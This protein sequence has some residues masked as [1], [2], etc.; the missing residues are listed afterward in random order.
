[1]GFSVYL[2]AETE[3]LVH[4]KQSANSALLLLLAREFTKSVSITAQDNRLGQQRQGQ[5]H[6]ARA[7]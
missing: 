6:R 2:L 5:G 7:T 1:M 3:T 4:Q